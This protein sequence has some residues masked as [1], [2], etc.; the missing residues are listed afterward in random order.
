MTQ[1]DIAQ[2]WTFNSS[3]GSS[4]YETLQY[5][6]GS[7]S[8]NC[9]GWTIKRAG[10]ERSCKHTRMVD[11]GIANDQ[12]VAHKDYRE[13]QTGTKKAAAQPK[14]KKQNPLTSGT[15]SAGGGRKILWQ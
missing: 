14:A 8:C 10:K 7:T 12:C 5:V 6:D 3:S 2:V 1:K 9:R 15:Q 4:T 13:L 11:Q